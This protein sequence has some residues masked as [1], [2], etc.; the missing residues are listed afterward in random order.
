[1]LLPGGR[2]P[3]R[4][5]SAPPLRP[6]G[7]LLAAAIGVACGIYDLHT[8]RSDT[9]A[10]FLGGAALVLALIVPAGAVPRAIVMGLSIPAVY[11]AAT[12]LDLTIPFPPTPHYAVTIVALVPALAGALLGLAVRKLIPSSGPPRRT[13]L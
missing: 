11:L 1:M 9:M 10:L 5:A 7:F 13:R 8:G 12:L 4:S 2:K 6:A 3:H